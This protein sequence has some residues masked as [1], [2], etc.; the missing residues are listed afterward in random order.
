M[1]YFASTVLGVCVCV[2]GGMVI[3]LSSDG[4]EF[5]LG[6]IR[7]IRYKDISKFIVSWRNFIIYNT[8]F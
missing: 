6:I 5:A 4:Q 7:F 1:A 2:W 3:K 8:Y